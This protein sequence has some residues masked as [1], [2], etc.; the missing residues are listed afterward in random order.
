MP[1]HY[2]SPLGAGGR[3]EHQPADRRRR[4]WAARTPRGGT[5]RDGPRARAGARAG[6]G[7]RAEARLRGAAPLQCPGSPGGGDGGARR[8]E[9][10]SP[11]ETDAGRA[12]APRPAAPRPHGGAPRGPAAAPG[13]AA[14]DAAVARRAAPRRRR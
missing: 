5:G 6:G 3:D 11:A 8:K 9:R 13:R 14:A 12:A 1:R 4:R 7:R 10:G 2:G